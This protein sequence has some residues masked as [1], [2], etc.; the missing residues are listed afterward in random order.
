MLERKRLTTIALLVLMCGMLMPASRGVAEAW[1]TFGAGW[2]VERGNG[3]WLEPSMFT[4]VT[5]S[6]VTKKNPERVRF[7]IK[8]HASS[9]REFSFRWHLYCWTGG[10]FVTIKGPD[11]NSVRIGPGKTVVREKTFDPSAEWCRM[12]V[13]VE[14]PPMEKGR[15]TVKLEATY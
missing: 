9:A 12:G 5:V 15:A 3:A 13:R 11:S 1:N 4:D 8:N 7:T 10:S 6:S 2:T 14:H